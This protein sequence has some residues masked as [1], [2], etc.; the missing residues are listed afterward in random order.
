[1]RT[2]T[3]ASTW[4]GD[5]RLRR[6]DYLAG[7]LHATVDRPRMHEHLAWGRGGVR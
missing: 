3:P 4:R 7:E 1:M 5:D 6:V 2:T